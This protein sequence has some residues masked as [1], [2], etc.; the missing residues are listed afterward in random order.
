MKEFSVTLANQP[1]QLAT[2]ARRLADAGV[3]IQ[4]LAAIG[5]NDESLLRLMPD[6]ADAT[7]RV[8]RDA[9]LHFEERL[10]L[11]TFLPDEPGALAAV[12]QRLADAGVNIDSMYLLHSNAEGLHF[13][14]TVDDPQ[15][16]RANLP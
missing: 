14:V 6:D 5:S 16:A 12:A 4:S 10:V 15:A 9:G 3:H 11:D 7:R 8:L 2:L 1:G 13:A